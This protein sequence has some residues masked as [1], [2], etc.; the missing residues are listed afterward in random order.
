MGIEPT[1]SKAT[2]WRSNRL[3][4]GLHL[5]LCTIS[6]KSKLNYFY[7]LISTNQQSTAKHCFARTKPVSSIQ[8]RSNSGIVFQIKIKHCTCTAYG[9]W[10]RATAVKGRRPRPLDERGINDQIKLILWALIS[11]CQTLLWGDKRIR[12]AVRG[13]AD[14]CLTTRPCRLFNTTQSGSNIWSLFNNNHLFSTPVRTWTAK[15]CFAT[16]KPVSYYSIRIQQMIVIQ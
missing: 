8:K 14:L 6:K 4:Y 10:T 1:A 12:T 15:H 11:I 13:F 3:S 5:K 16:T 9:I 2:T 7:N